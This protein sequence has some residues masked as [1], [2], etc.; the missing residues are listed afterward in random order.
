[1]KCS[2][3]RTISLMSHT[4]KVLLTIV[5]RRMENR[6]DATL[7][8][9]QFG[10]RAKKGT[11]VAVVLFKTLIQRSLEV[12]RQIYVCYVD[13]EKAFDR[14]EHSKLMNMLEK[15]EVDGEDVHLIQNLYWNQKANIRIGA[16]DSSEACCVKRGVRQ[17]CPMSPRLFNA[18]SERIMQHPKFSNVG[19]PINGLKINNISYADD[20]VMIAASPQQL[21]QMI[22]RLNA[23]GKKVGMN[24]NTS[25]TKVMLIEKKVSGKQLRIEVDSQVLQQVETFKYLGVLIRND[26]KDD[27]EI[28]CRIAS[29]RNAFYNL[30]YVLKDRKLK[31][32]TRCRILRCYVW[33]VLRYTSEAW[34]MTKKVKARIN[35]FELWCYRRMLRI[36]WTKKVKNV[37]VLAR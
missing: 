27:T 16:S 6:I 33:S 21:Q 26:G 17:G 19:F 29:A 3:Y 1:M 37:E 8:Q 23:E 7:S 35:A 9:M 32:T 14:V 13:Y 11:R 31:F 12:N 30:E 34:I 18:Y 10:F 28:A 2:D 4:L 36:A 5:N 25:K 22:S 15:Y 24:I 20:K